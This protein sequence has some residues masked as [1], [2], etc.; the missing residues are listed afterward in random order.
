MS[1]I[2]TSFC[3]IFDSV[4]VD[5]RYIL[6]NDDRNGLRLIFVTLGVASESPRMENQI[7]KKPDINQ[8]FW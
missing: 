8:V 1:D 3:F 5:H 4:N 2:L 6:S 7:D